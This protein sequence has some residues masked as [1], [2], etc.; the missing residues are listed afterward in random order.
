VRH[1]IR[2]PVLAL[3]LGSAISAAPPQHKKDSPDPPPPW[4]F[5]IDTPDI[6]LQPDD[7]TLERV[8]DSPV[9]LT[10]TQVRDIFSVPDWHP[11]GHP[12]MPKVVARGREPELRACGYCHL[13]NGLGR[14][15]NSSLAGLPAVYFAEQI[16]DFKSGARKSSEPRMRPPS[17]MLVV[18]KAVTNAEVKIAADYFTSLKLKRWIRVVES[19]TAP[20]TY[21]VGGMLLPL[22]SGEREPLGDRIVETPENAE[23]T[24]LRD[25]TSGFIAYVP[26][27]SIRKGEVLVTTGGAGKTIPCGMCHG[28]DLRGLGP[29]P[30]LAGRSPSY[31]FRQ[32]YDIQ[33]GSRSGQGVALMQPAVANL[34]KSDMLSIA[35]YTGS[36]AP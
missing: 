31:V 27:G 10:L 1:V 15:E 26:F 35:A 30:A 6:P 12:H 24:E 33:H 5:P 13:P 7:G 23:R 17:V 20:K 3:L 21:V 34:T 9:A 19:E 18:A 22:K 25:A 2:V 4:A 16:A 8:P 32:L 29:V 11:E 14:P 28:P 36:R